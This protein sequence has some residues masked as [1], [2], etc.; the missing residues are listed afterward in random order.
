MASWKLKLF[1]TSHCFVQHCPWRTALFVSLDEGSSYPPHRGDL[2]S[3]TQALGRAPQLPMLPFSMPRMSGRRRQ[4][5]GGRVFSMPDS[6]SLRLTVKLV[7]LYICR[8]NHSN[9]CS[10]SCVTTA[11]CPHLIY[12]YL[13]QDK[14]PHATFSTRA[15]VSYSNSKHVYP[16]FQ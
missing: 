2:S 10:S 7:K 15:T 1:S 14:Q 11:H 9:L 5:V 13:A 3:P 16:D 4:S 8:R 12:G 6:N